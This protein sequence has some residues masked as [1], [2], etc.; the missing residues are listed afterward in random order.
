MA[1]QSGNEIETRW[2]QD[3]LLCTERITSEDRASLRKDGGAAAMRV[4]STLDTTATA[5]HGIQMC[6]IQT[7]LKLWQER[8][9]LWSFAG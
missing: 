3:N 4:D 1:T 5:I 9:L 2:T 8:A 7:P 6:K